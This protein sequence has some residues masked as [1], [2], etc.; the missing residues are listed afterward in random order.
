MEQA[1]PS[2][3]YT[4]GD[5]IVSRG[6]AGRKAKADIKRNPGIGGERSGHS[7]G[8]PTASE[9]RGSRISEEHWG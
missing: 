7:Q 6:K 5:R 4:L 2:H 3:A 8:D 9:I 1:F